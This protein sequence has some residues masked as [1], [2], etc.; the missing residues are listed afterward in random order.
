MSTLT[1]NSRRHAVCRR[2]ASIAL[3]IDINNNYTIGWEFWHVSQLGS[4][5]SERHLLLLP[6]GDVNLHVFN[7]RRCRKLLPAWGES[8]SNFPSPHPL[9]FPWKVG[10]AVL[11]HTVTYYWYPFQYSSGTRVFKYR[12]VRPLVLTADSRW[13]NVIL[14]QRKRFAQTLF[15][16][17]FI[18]CIQLSYYDV[19]FPVWIIRINF[20]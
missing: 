19:N 14:V 4:E 5:S 1:G 15:L 11:E 2:Q 17:C 10:Q 12:E 13:L 9:P 7:S 20:Y 6:L 16:L 3:N 8:R 18:G